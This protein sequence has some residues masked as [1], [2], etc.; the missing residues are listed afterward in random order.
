MNEYLTIGVLRRI[1]AEN[2]GLSDDTRVIKRVWDR[3]C[4]KMVDGSLFD[5][6]LSIAEVNEAGKLCEEWGGE[7]VGDI[8]V[9]I[10]D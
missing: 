6:R 2:E 7:P 10:I 9:L 3:D 5:A 1:L 4:E 8:P